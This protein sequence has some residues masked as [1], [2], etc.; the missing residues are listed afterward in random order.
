MTATD[1]NVCDDE[2]TQCIF[3]IKVVCD[4]CPISVFYEN[5]SPGGLPL[6]ALTEAG[7]RIVA[8]ESVDPGQ[9]DGPVLTGTAA[10]E[11]RAPEIL[12]EPGFVGGVNFLAIP[13]PNTCLDDCDA[14]C[15]D[16]GGFTVD[17]YDFNGDGVYDE[18]NQ[19]FEPDGDGW[20]DFWQVHDA[21]H[22]FCAYGAQAYELSI[23]VAASG[24]GNPVYY[25]YENPEG[26]CPFE[27]RAPE[28][29]VPH[30]S[31]YWD[32]TIN[33][34]NWNCYGCMVTTGAYYA[35]ILH[36]YGCEGELTFT[37]LIYVAGSSGLAP[38][39]GA[40]YMDPLAANNDLRISQLVPPDT[41][42]G[43]A[44]F[45]QL[46]PN[47]GSDLVTLASDMDILDV[48]VVDIVGQ[49]IAAYSGIADR[50]LQVSVAYWAK[51]EYI[52]TIRRSSGRI[53]RL[54]FVK[55]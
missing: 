30:S 54:R 3:D 23:F 6:P 22:A 18:L 7:W 19:G 48:I 36:L 39:I 41:T 49:Q 10:V 55:T 8:G 14:C 53:D 17:T 11:F 35:Y 28:N 45:L 13:D 16:W 32:G 42:F 40:G 26:C 44:A 38:E 24:W 34:G 27:S 51:G 43:S 15:D 29:Q 31:I 47:P 9:T 25:V 4:F 21:D 33:A 12:L 5:R 20:Q 2:G 46:F 37:G 50:T 52:F 1:L